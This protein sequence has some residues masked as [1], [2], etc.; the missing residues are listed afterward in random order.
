M[1]LYY[2]TPLVYPSR[3][4]N[5]IQVIKMSEA[6]SR[7][8]ESFRL[9]VR[10]LRGEKSAIFKSYSVHNS[11]KIE[12]LGTPSG[13][14]RSLFFAFRARYLL[15]QEQDAVWFLRDG[16]LAYWLTFLAGLGSKRFF[17][18]VHAFERLPKFI[19][20]RIFKKAT[21]IITTNQKKAYDLTT[22]F[23]VLKEK[24]F[25]SLNGADIKSYPSKISLSDARTKFHLPTDKKIAL[26]MGVPSEE[27]GIKTFLKAA[28]LLPPDVQMVSVGG[29]REE[30]SKLEND[31]NFG[32]IIWIEQIP[33]ENVPDCLAA[34][35][36]LVAPFSGK[37]S[38][39]LLYTSP[40]KI[41]IYMA[42]GKAIIASDLPS[43]REFIGE[44]EAFFFKADEPKSLA[45][46]IRGALKSP[47]IMLQRGDRAKLKAEMFSWDKRAQDIIQFIKKF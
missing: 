35:E 14:P 2:L 31:P 19:Y 18:E 12:A 24:I 1:K 6:F 26:Y 9:Y 7:L 34:A 29:S 43:V 15:K 30:I 28:S 42:S 11:F 8:A 39:T 5:R 38:W 17:F 33:Y 4:A 37:T 32:K 47:K 22:K 41:P 27:K 45:E 3:Y 40:L 20:S 23:G 46:T 44:D 36:V 16:L 13:F 21:G 25:V 10:E